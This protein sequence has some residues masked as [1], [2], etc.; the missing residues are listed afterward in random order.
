[1]AARRIEGRTKTA[2]GS[3][4]MNKI[5]NGIWSG[6]ELGPIEKLSIRSFI[7]NGHEFRLWLAGPTTGIP[8]GTRICDINDMPNLK[9]RLWFSNARHWSDYVRINL[10][11]HFGGFYSD[12]DVVC[13]KFWD[14]ADPIVLTSEDNMTGKRDPSTPFRPQSEVPTAAVNNCII[15]APAGAGFLKWILDQIENRDI[16]N[17]P[18]QL[19]DGKDGIGFQLL[20]DVVPI[21]GLEQFVKAPIVL[22]ALSL[23]EYPRFITGGVDWNISDKSYAMHLRRTCWSNPGERWVLDANK[24]YPNDCLFEK[25]KKKHGIS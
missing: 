17:I 8:E 13:L 14:F 21:A 23:D 1:V 16:K 9:L 15:K 5:I 2:I 6:P 22:D 11:Y 10:L 24:E 7:D 20:R 25:L 3:K 19:T 18:D 12:I 4:T